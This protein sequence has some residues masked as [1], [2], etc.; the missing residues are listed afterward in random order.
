M[1]LI[2]IPFISKYEFIILT[3]YTPNLFKMNLSTDG[4]IFW[5]WH[6]VLWT[7]HCLHLWNEDGPTPPP[8]ISILQNLWLCYHTWQK[9]F[10]DMINVKGFEMERLSWIIRMGSMYYM[11]P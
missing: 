1:K 4:S 2:I 9:E 8:T 10:A 6:I 3:Y 7:E 5:C 11:G